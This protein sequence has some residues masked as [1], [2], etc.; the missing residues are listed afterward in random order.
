MVMT[1]R[2]KQHIFIVDDEPGVRTVV[3][4]TLERLDAEDRCFASGKDCLKQLRR[5]RCNLLITDVKM[6]GMD[7][8]ELLAEAKRISP[9]LMVLVMTGYGDVPMAVRAM[10]MG[11][12]DFLEKPVGTENLLHAAESALARTAPS[13]PHVGRP[14][15]KTEMRILDLI[16]AGKTS[17]EIS[18]ILSRSIKTIEVH[19]SHIMHKFDVDNVVDLTKRAFEL[20]L[21]GVSPNE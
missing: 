15:T 13:N 17:K 7:G 3:G 19:R 10:R 16:L 18:T 1:K 8:L 6:P 4:K 21:I 5:K 12:L 14:L 11:A 9:C 2:I 20:G